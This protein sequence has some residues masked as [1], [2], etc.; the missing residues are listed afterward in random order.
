[1]CD[2]NDITETGGS[3]NVKS[4]ACFSLG[5]GGR[6]SRARGTIGVEV[7]RMDEYEFNDK[8]NFMS[9]AKFIPWRVEG[10]ICRMIYRV[11][12][13]MMNVP[14]HRVYLLLPTRITPMGPSHE[15]HCFN[16][17]SPFNQLG[18]IIDFLALIIAI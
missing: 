3:L 15:I 2:V 8:E 9:F 12:C 5:S 6:V 16:F 13:C 18:S 1:M 14:R 17:F 7:Q 11:I 10:M 4:L